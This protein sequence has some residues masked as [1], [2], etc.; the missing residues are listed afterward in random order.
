M[1]SACNHERVPSG[2]LKTAHIRVDRLEKR[3]PQQASFDPAAV[4]TRSSRTRRIA[5]Q[6][7]DLMSQR[8]S[9]HDVEREHP[10]HGEG[11]AG[12]VQEHV[13]AHFDSTA[14]YWD[15]VYRD[16]DV[17][18]LIY[19]MRQAVVLDNVVAAKLPHEAPVLEIGCGAGH[20]TAELAGRGLRVDAVDASQAMVDVTA[21]RMAEAGLAERVTVATADVHAL[22][23]EADSFD[24]VVA[25]G[26]IPWLHSPGDAVREMARVLRPGGQ[27]ILTADN[28]ARLTSFTDPRAILALT[29][30]RRAWVALRRRRGS[31]ASSRL[32]FPKRIDELLAQSGLRPLARRTVGFGPMSFLGRSV[33][34]EE[35]SIEINDRLQA[36]ADRGVPGL[37]WT[38]WHYVVRAEKLSGD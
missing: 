21:S 29:P 5:G 2:P 36:M 25:V 16:G 10:T 24:L 3:P 35:R 11:R 15:A 34:R 32:D 20:L 37:R 18:G 4:Q 26:V 9:E 1:S 6:V 7:S 8:N 19:R 23:F 13:T 38:G 14:S 28:R 22:P 30:L 33:F 12:V 17:Q 31:L 27:V